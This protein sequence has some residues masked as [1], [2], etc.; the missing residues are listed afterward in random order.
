MKKGDPA[1]HI[2]IA[3][4]ITERKKAEEAVKQ[5]EKRFQD[6]YDSAP[7]MY[8]SITPTGKVKS[9]NKFGADY[10]GYNEGE[11][12][13]QEVW[14][15]VHP[16]DRDLVVERI[17]EIFSRKL[18]SAKLEF[19]KVRKDGSII[20]VNESTRL[21]S[22]ING[23]PKELFIICRDITSNKEFQ[24]A[25]LESEQKYRKLAQNAPVSVARFSM[26][27]NDFEYANDEFARQ[28]GCSVDEYSRLSREEKTNIIYSE[29]RKK[30]QDNYDE[31]K[32]NGF[33]GMLHFDYRILNRKNVLIWL[34]TFIYA[35]FDDSGRAVMM[36]EIC[37]DITERKKS[38]ADIT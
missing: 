26:T 32:K 17:S 20:W 19:R 11:L 13:G 9:V 10:L 30:V 25:L 14:K 6:L 16:D 31:W 24:I 34:D 23:I 8:F 28:M 4:D 15:V 21:I 29:D 35:D 5:S 22:D 37:I 7:D 36:N 18:E 33:K 27:T 3:S 12:I 2:G 1:A 38:R